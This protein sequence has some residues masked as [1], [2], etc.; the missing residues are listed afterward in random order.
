VPKLPGPATQ[1]GEHMESA[2]F[3]KR[4]VRTIENQSWLEPAGESIQHAMGQ[5]YDALGDRAG[6]V[7]RLLHGAWLGHPAHPMLTDVPVGAW[8]VAFV[9]DAADVIFQ[10]RDLRAGADASIVLGLLAGT[11]TAWTGW[12]DWQYTSGRTRRTA[13]AH[14]LLNLGAAGLYVVSIA[15]RQSGARG[16][17]QVVSTLGYGTMIG[18]AYLGGELVFDRL[19]GTNRAPDPEEPETF[20]TVASLDEID[21]NTPQ[22]F[23]VDGET[24]VVVRRGD[25]VVALAD[26][27]AHLGVSLAGGEVRDGCIVCAAHGSTYSLDDGRVVSGPAAFPQPVFDVR[28]R[29]GEVEIRA[30][31]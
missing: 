19:V 18:G 11:V 1:K 5:F 31:T 2:K 24:V 6:E 8:T 28:V 3:L 9:F 23:E 27:C 7:K 22:Q 12:A 30:R 15:L 26:S 13:L 25:S 21:E 10:R 20:T 16:A 29:D 4:L 17:G 14:G